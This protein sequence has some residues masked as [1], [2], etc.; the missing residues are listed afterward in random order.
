M[1]GA[2]TSSSPYLISTPSDLQAIDNNLGAYY[3]LANDIDMTG[4]SF[5]PIGRTYPFFQGYLDGK[6]HKVT[7]LRIV[8]TVEYTAFI[9]RTNGGDIKNIGLEN[10]YVESN[11][12]HVGGL[13]ALNSLSNFI[14]N[15]WVT[16]TIKQTSTSKLYCGGL[17]GRNYG[18]VDNC[19]SDCTVL[20]GDSVGGFSGV[21]NYANSIIKNCYSKSTV[22]GSVNVGAFFGTSESTVIYEDCFYD[23]QLSGVTNT[24]RTGVT[25]KTTVGMKTQSTYD[26][27]DFNTVWYM[28]EYPALRVFA[29]DIPT[30][31]KE[32]V[33]VDSYVSTIQSNL[34]NSKK[35]TVQLNSYLYPFINTLN[36]RRSVLETV[37]CYLSNLHSNA[38]E[39]HRIVLNAIRQV[40]S[41]IQP[42]YSK[43]A[44]F[45]PVDDIPVFG[46]VLAI[47]NNSTTSNSVN[48]SELSYI[49]NPSVVEVI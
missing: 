21:I 46:E 7:N 18:N 33:T 9:A 36:V 30:I 28:N 6:G 26:N 32:T 2:G 24:T 47:E 41:Y 43:V 39:S 5:T 17:V 13:V 20:G 44:T 25:G 45:Y 15:C 12:H 11:N 4:I 40:D 34:N 16:G 27:W 3:E 8:S 23:N 48:M 10:I 49:I 31:N 14:S 1:Q 19:Y 29:K 38:T 35:S 42:I 22:N 37:E